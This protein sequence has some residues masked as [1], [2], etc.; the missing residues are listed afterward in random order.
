MSLFSTLRTGATGLGVSS[1]DLSVIGDNIANIGT[2]G[3][4]QSRAT[5]ADYLPNDV[6][7]MNGRSQLGM[8]ASSNGIDILFGQGSI[9]S[10]GV[11]SD[12]AINGAGL[13]VVSDGTDQYYT[14]AG[15]FTE[16]DL[17]YLTL[18]SNRLQG[19]TA[20]D[21][22]LSSVL[23]DISIDHSALPGTP[24]S[25]IV[26]DAELSAGADYS[27]VPL[28]ALAFYGTGA[29][30]ATLSDA[31]AAA[32]FTTSV[33]IYDSLGQPHEATVLFER[34][35]SNTWTWH[36]VTDATQVY[37][38]TGNP[39]STTDGEAFEFATG[40]LT[41]DTDGNLTASSAPTTAAGWSFAGSAEPVVNFD[42]GLDATGLV[43]AGS[44][45]MHGGDSFVSAIT[46]DGTATGS[47]NSWSVDAEG[48]IVAQYSNG[49]SRTLGQVVLATF[50]TTDGLQRVGQSLFDATAAA[51]EPVIGAPG[52]GG[53]GSIAAYSLEKSNVE[54]EDQFVLM[55]TAQR[56]YQ[57]NSKVIS[58]ASDTLS[59]LLQ[60]V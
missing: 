36:A 6:F 35:G 40:T 33:T 60:I 16:D 28:S 45:S 2:I 13:F 18:G 4:K 39:V 15:N 7:G 14:R 49:E 1:L 52:Q 50:T 24:T 29:G 30:G 43:T 10:T 59:S 48:K 34:T 53:L 41:F 23:G 19:Y 42:F 27:T 11:A 38:A 20:T 8:G 21:G 26:L 9:S 3:Y 17:G 47:L 57:A 12:L 32:D 56:A 51:G 31:A 44:V 58:T 46:Q 5:F 25:S 37:D 22:V 55:I 54:L